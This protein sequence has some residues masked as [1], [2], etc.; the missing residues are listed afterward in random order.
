M[1][2]TVPPQV[3]QYVVD[4][5]VRLRKISKDDELANKSHTYTSARTLLGVL[6]LS[7]AL[8][9]LRWATMVAIEDVDEALRLMDASKE[10]LY[11]EEDE[12]ERR[13]RE[14]DSSASSKI[15]RLIKGMAGLG[16]PKTKG[17]R[18]LGKGPGGQRDMDE[19]SDEDGE[20]E[21]SIVDIRSRVLANGFTEYQLMETI[22]EVVFPPRRSLIRALMIFHSMRGLISGC[23]LRTVVSCASS[24]RSVAFRNGVTD[25][26]TFGCCL[27]L[28]LCPNVKM[29][30]N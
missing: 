7:Q 14:G 11:D 29:L 6:R 27:W 25:V 23:G 1:R 16:G 28:L 12:T 3:S 24:T 15:F 2:P 30:S 4:S 26:C 13:R 19:D 18:R 22:T 8:A 17:V 10:S 9:R 21:L 5:Y 20:Q